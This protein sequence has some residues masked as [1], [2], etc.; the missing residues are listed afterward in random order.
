MKR[1]RPAVA[2]ALAAL[3]LA[4]LPAAL[5]AQPTAVPD[6]A[7]Y[8][9]PEDFSS[10]ALYATGLVGVGARA[11]GMAGNYTGI[12]DDATAL[13]YNPAGLAQ[14]LRIEVDLGMH[15]LNDVS[16]SSM[17]GVA[18][19][20]GVTHT[21]IDHAAFAYPFPTYRGSLVAGFGVFR[22]RS[23]DLVEARRDQRRG[24]NYTFNDE[25]RR[26]Q[27][28]GVYRYT[29]GFGVDLMRSLSF[30]ASISYWEGQ[31]QDDQYRRIDEVVTGN[32]PLRYEDRLVTESDV[33]GFSFD[34]GLLGYVSRRARLGLVLHSP[35]W[36]DIEG[37]GE[38]V[39]E[40]TSGAESTSQLLYIDQ[41][42]S[43]PWSLTCGGSVALGP[44]LVAGDLRFAA[45]DEIDLDPV[46]F[47]PGDDLPL[48]SPGYSSTMGGGVGVEVA[49][50][51]SPLRLRGGFSYDPEPYDLLLGNPATMV[52]ERRTWTIGGG[53]QLAD[54]FVLDAGYVNATF[55]RAD[56]TYAAV[57]ENRE[58]RRYYLTAGYRY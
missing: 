31:L 30:G 50:P 54:A 44:L 20:A 11:M 12:A 19:P 41:Q 35:V 37:G 24:T 29:G 10:E 4:A 55:E 2:A 18:T 34:L 33:D 17:F 39:R 15:H 32:V 38:R 51:R 6:P 36:Y 43:V 47:G 46:S 57:T 5:R 22:A 53:L 21:G 48:E 27:Q 56:A 9:N 58:Q 52:Q 45:W 13:V 16:T 49:V 28:G 7:R 40:A 3:L 42:P 8:F 14:L 25:F 23:N 26:A 1:A